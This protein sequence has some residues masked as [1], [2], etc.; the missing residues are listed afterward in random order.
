MKKEDY[1]KFVLEKCEEHFEF[2]K[3][4]IDDNMTKREELIFENGFLNG[5]LEA[6]KRYI[7]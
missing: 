1:K 3:K 5:F 7:K 4:K 2:L 6:Q